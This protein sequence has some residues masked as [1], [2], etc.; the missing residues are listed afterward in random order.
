MPRP[1]VWDPCWRARG[2]ADG[3]RS[4]PLAAG[5]EDGL[6]GRPEEA[7]Q[8]SLVQ[9]SIHGCNT[10]ELGQHQQ[11]REKE[12]ISRQ[13]DACGQHLCHRCFVRQRA[14]CFTC[15]TL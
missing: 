13:N 7:G 9:M 10:P 4:I 15:V 5:V 2:A 1:P 11:E 8:V 14:L 12:P 6:E 3:F